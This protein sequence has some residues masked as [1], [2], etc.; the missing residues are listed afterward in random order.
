MRLF[1]KIKFSC[2]IGLLFMSFTPWPTSASEPE[3]V[4]VYEEPR[5]RVVFE[6]DH[7]F[8]LHVNIPPG[9]TSLYHKHTRNLFYVH[10]KGSRVWA[11]PL[12]GE[13]READVKSGDLRFSSDNH[14]LPHIHR[15]GNL[16]TS[17]FDLIGIGIKDSI[18]EDVVP[19]E[20]DSSGMTMVMEK[21]HARIYRSLLKPG[22]N[23]GVD[24][25]NLPFTRVYVNAGKLLNSAG[26]TYLVDA[27]DY[28]WQDAGVEHGLQNVGD[29]DIEIIEMQWR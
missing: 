26:D 27:G 20:G 1:R 6:N 7:V 8:I 2:L 25:H 13:R 9:Y 23:T 3:W 29:E 19:L 21:P 28:L 24:R 14:G 18:S 12:N 10:I 11:Q 16:G 17:E 22:E 15:V 4:P 5:H